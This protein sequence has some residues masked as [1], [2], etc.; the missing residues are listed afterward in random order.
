MKTIEERAKEYVRRLWKG[1][2]NGEWGTL[3]NRSKNDFIAGAKSERKELLKW[4]DP[5]KELPEQNKLVLLKTD[6]GIYTGSWW[7]GIEFGVYG[8]G[9]SRGLLRSELKGSEDDGYTCCIISWRP[10][11]EL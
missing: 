7:G 10:I 4:R 6:E 9:F 8:N 11:E 5:K 1:Y 3:K 2:S